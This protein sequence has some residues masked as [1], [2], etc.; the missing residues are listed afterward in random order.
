[1]VLDLLHTYGG[2]RIDQVERLLKL[3]PDYHTKSFERVV[4]I[5]KGSG[6]ISETP[7]I[8]TAT[9]SGCTVAPRACTFGWRG[10][11]LPTQAF[12]FRSDLFQTAKGQAVLSTIFKALLACIC[13]V[14]IHKIPR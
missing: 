5:L 3:R 13:V 7:G 8:L 9:D 1:M 12:P 2:L 6:R 4:A 10:T 11:D 14:G